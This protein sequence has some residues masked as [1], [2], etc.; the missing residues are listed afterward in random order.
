MLNNSTKWKTTSHLKSLNTKNTTTY[1]DEN[2][3]PGFEQQQEQK[4]DRVKEINGI[5]ALSG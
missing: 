3:D 2:P 4:C 5:K 1:A